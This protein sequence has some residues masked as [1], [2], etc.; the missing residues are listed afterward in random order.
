MMPSNCKSFFATH[1]LLL[2]L[3]LM[4][5]ASYAQQFSQRASR[6]GRGHD[7]QPTA[8]SP[9]VSQRRVVHSPSGV[10]FTFGT[11][12][13][14]RSPDTMATWLGS[15]DLVF[16]PMKA[17]N[18]LTCSRAIPSRSSSIPALPTHLDLESTKAERS[19]VGM[20]DRTAMPTP[21]FVKAK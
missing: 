3:A 1:L 6:F 2:V 7:A 19:W 17:Q 16:P 15:L 13:F 21:F 18:S 12:E 20:P 4:P 8:V 5:L 9:T 14:P 10:T 11:I